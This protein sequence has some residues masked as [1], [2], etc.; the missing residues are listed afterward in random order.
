M[1]KEIVTFLFPYFWYK[2]GVVWGLSLYY[3]NYTHFTNYMRLKSPGNS[4]LKSFEFPCSLI[5]WMLVPLSLVKLESFSLG[6]PILL[7]QDSNRVLRI[8]QVRFKDNI[9]YFNG[10]IGNPKTF[11]QL[12]HVEH[13][14]Y[15]RQSFGEL[16][17]IRHWSTLLK[18][19]EWTNVPR[20]KLPF[21][22]ETRYALHWWNFQVDIISHEKV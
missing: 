2:A 20:C 22:P 17:S 18:Y 9:Y 12:G 5:F 19:R 15:N 21:N 1:E 14:M 8:C 4:Y 16:K 10:S 11:L 13:I 7:I 6:N 3:N